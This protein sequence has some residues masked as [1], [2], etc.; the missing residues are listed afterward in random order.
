MPVIRSKYQ[1]FLGIPKNSQIGIPKNLYEFLTISYG[2][3]GIPRA[4]GERT[5]AA[6]REI[7][8]SLLSIS[9]SLLLVLFLSHHHHHSYYHHHYYS[10]CHYCYHLFFLL[11]CLSLNRPASQPASQAGSLP[12]DWASV[13][14]PSVRRLCCGPRAA[15]PGD[16]L[17]D[18]RLATLLA[19]DECLRIPGNP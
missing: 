14:G 12:A 15:G 16:R 5:S 19:G 9:L 18:G 4:E 6:S 8:E 1:A 3:I 10:Y 7:I 11:L 17:P 2:F 13:H